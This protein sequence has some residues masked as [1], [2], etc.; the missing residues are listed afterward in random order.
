MIVDE[1][2][3]PEAFT[4]ASSSSSLGKMYTFSVLE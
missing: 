2:L 4:S 1:L 3:P